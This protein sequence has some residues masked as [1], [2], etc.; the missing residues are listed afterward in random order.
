[1]WLRGSK[2]GTL[3][4]DPQACRS[5]CDPGPGSQAPG[6]VGTGGPCSSPAGPQRQS[7]EPSRKQCLRPGRR[8]SLHGNSPKQTRG[9]D[10][11]GAAAAPRPA[12]QQVSPPPS[13]SRFRPCHLSQVTGSEGWVQA[14]QNP[15][16]PHLQRQSTPSGLAFWRLAITP[17]SPTIS[18]I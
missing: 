3:C 15:P 11:L 2:C 10:A 14:R 1:M 8:T 13:G 6:R 4:R 12:Q 18:S 17:L 16:P 5:E 9:P 7:S